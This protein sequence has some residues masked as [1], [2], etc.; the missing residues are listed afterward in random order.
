MNIVGTYCVVPSTNYNTRFVL[1]FIHQEYIK[2][3][4]HRTKICNTF[5]FPN[6]NKTN[7]PICTPINTMAFSINSQ[8]G[9]KIILYCV[10]AISTCTFLVTRF[11]IGKSLAKIELEIILT[12]AFTQ[13][14][15][16]KLINLSF[17]LVNCNVVSMKSN[18]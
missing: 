11:W 1:S 6:T 12:S 7:A 3:T 8:T 14:N 15:I 17:I 4:K 10:I 5:I 18:T 16:Y 9:I 13:Q 2:S